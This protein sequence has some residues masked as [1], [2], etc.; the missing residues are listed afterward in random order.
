MDIIAQIQSAVKANNVIIGHKKSVEYIKN[1]SPELVVI[2]NNI[3]EDKK[4]ELEHDAK[5]SG[6]RVEVFEGSSKDLGIICGKPFPISVLVIK[7]G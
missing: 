7:S 3:E 1:N 6:V 5:I 2:A 4:R